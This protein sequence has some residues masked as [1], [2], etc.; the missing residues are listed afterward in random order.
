[1]LPIST[2]KKR[3]TNNGSPLPMSDTASGISVSEVPSRGAD[4]LASIRE[5]FIFSPFGLCCRKCLKSVQIQ[6]D[7]RC[8][9]DHLKK[10]D[11]DSRVATVRSVLESFLTQ[12]DKVKMSR[13][14]EL[15]RSDKSIYIGF[16]CICGTSFIKKGN[17][18]RH[19]KNTGCDASKL[20]NIEL[21]KLCCGRYVSQ[22]QV[23]SFFDEAPRIKEQFD[24]CKA[25]ATLLP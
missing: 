6:L 11:I 8:I 3:K 5:L 9:R 18:I 24:Y 25:R 15:Y 4:I 21:I 13:T 1:M 7:E 16:S 19:C 17:A 22:A 23:A 14:I 20:Q 10:H 12:R 2:A